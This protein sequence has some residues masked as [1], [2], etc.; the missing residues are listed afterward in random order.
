MP[1]TKQP[2]HETT[3]P[4]VQLARLF[5]RLKND[6]VPQQLIANYLGVTTQKITAICKHAKK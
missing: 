4:T 3:F 1:K 5:K 6:G 2:L